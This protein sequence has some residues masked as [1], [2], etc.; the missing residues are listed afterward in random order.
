[1]LPLHG[2]MFE[3]NLNLNRVRTWFKNCFENPFVEAHPLS[4]WKKSVGGPSTIAEVQVWSV[5]SK[6]RNL[7]SLNF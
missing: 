5:N 7:L 4:L 2:F 3:K 1:M 6:T